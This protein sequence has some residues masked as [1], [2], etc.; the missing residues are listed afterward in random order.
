[1]STPDYPYA[2]GV[3]F[4]RDKRYSYS[5]Y[6]GVSFL[7]AWRLQRRAILEQ[8]PT[9]QLPPRTDILTLPDRDSIDTAE[10]LDFL[11]GSLVSDKPTDSMTYRLVDQLVRRF[12]VFR[13]IHATYDE[14][15]RAVDKMKFEN[16]ELYIR[17]AEVFN[18]AYEATN[19][20]TYLNVLLKIID[21]LSANAENLSRA[22]AGRLVNVI[23]REGDHIAQLVNGLRIA[24]A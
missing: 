13:R 15:F 2:S 18:V 1:M 20:L 23:K 10:L 5:Q 12:E 16:L 22:Q 8:L 7:N 3:T 6:H 24:N 11:Y 21:S 9:E 4:E 17:A 14:Q 19:S